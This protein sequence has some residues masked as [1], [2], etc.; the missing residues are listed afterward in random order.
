MVLDDAVAV[1]AVASSCEEEVVVLQLV[2][3]AGTLVETAGLKVQQ[4]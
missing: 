4:T 3:A 1:A 2:A